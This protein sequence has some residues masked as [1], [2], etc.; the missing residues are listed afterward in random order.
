MGAAVAGEADGARQTVAALGPSPYAP[1]SEMGGPPD[2]AL[3]YA[4]A[5]AGAEAAL[6]ERSPWTA[7]AYE[8]MH[9]HGGQLFGNLVLAGPTGAYM[10]AIAPLAD[11]ADDLDALLATA[12]EACEAMGSPV[13]A[14][15]ARVHGACGLRCATEPVTATAPHA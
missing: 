7:S 13:L 8:Q 11:H 15:Y 6:G 14:M 10:A 4:A 5:F 9:P 1:W 2:A 3:S 12:L